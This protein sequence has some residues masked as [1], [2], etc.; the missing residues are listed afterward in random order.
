LD[1]V[2]CCSLNRRHQEMR[3]KK[4]RFNGF[5]EAPYRFRRALASS[6][7]PTAWLKCRAVPSGLHYRCSRSQA[8]K[9]GAV[10]NTWPGPNRRAYSA[11]S[12]KT[13]LIGMAGEKCTGPPVVKFHSLVPLAAF[14]AYTCRCQIQ[15][16]PSHWQRRAMT[17]WQPRKK[18]PERVDGAHVVGS[19]DISHMG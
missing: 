15:H 4:E 6:G 19:E 2:S 3:A 12:T 1:W 10:G 17:S 18:T 16:R 9:A 5:C 13:R 14:S 7:K 11:F 8:W